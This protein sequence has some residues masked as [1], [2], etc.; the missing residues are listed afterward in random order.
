MKPARMT[1]RLELEPLEDRCTPAILGPQAPPFPPPADQ[2][3]TA[4]SAAS[5]LSQEKSGEVTL[6]LNVDL[7]ADTR[8]WT[9]TG[10][11]EDSGTA[12]TVWVQFGALKSPVRS[13][14]QIDTL[15]TSVDGTG[16]FTIRRTIIER[17]DGPNRLAR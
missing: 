1:A 9:A 11:I 14:V 16:T 10:A 3:L 5:L 15:F 17:A 13:V 8:T 4:A 7:A 2:A 12:A 6:T